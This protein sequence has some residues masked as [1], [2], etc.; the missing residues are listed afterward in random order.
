MRRHTLNVVFPLLVLCIFALSASLLVVV[1]ASG[2]RRMVERGEEHYEVNTA[3]A[4]LREK[5]SSYDEADGIEI[6]EVDGMECLILKEEHMHTYIY[7]YEGK[8]MELTVDDNINP[9]FIAGTPVL[10]LDAV[11]F[12]YDNDH[13]LRAD[14]NYQEDHSTAVFYIASLEDAS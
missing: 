11:S 7:V 14:L 9:N 6:D 8:L 5:I 10:S 4:Y 2:F 12:H 3:A 13:L 1:S